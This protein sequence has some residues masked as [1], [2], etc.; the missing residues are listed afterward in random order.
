MA[1]ICGLEAR[2]IMLSY[3]HENKR[4]EMMSRKIYRLL[5]VVFFTEMIINL[6]VLI[7]YFKGYF[8]TIHDPTLGFLI[9]IRLFLNIIGLVTVFYEQ[10]ISKKCDV[11]NDEK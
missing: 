3:F 9:V 8:A 6:D 10:G 2:E 1:S 7:Y 11:L 5:L 4:Y